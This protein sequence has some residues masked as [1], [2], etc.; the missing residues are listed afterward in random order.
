MLQNNESLF[1]YNKVTVKHMMPGL[2][3]DKDITLAKTMRN[4]SNFHNTSLSNNNLSFGTD[5]FAVI[6]ALI[7]QKKYVN[8]FYIFIYSQQI[9]TLGFKRTRHI[10][11]QCLNK[12]NIFL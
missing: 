10:F 11:P 5:G 1:I 8:N 3:T 12:V 9:K 6:A 4:N 7:T 2:V